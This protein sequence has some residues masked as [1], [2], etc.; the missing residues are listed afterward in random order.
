[1]DVYADSQH[2]CMQARRMQ[3]LNLWGPALPET[4]DPEPYI[5]V[6]LEST[7]G[8]SSAAASCLACSKTL[9]HLVKLCLSPDTHHAAAWESF[10]WEAFDGGICCPQISCKP[11]FRSSIPL[12]ISGPP[13]PMPKYSHLSPDPP[14]SAVQPHRSGR[15]SGAGG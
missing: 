9:H 2:I 15:A 12:W 14:R 13:E 6:A 10:A 4:L 11:N 8:S 3:Q 1:M 5:L 7:K